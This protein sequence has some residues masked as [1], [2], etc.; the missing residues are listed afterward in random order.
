[1]YFN[2]VSN[3]R[4]LAHT[5]IRKYLKPWFVKSAQKLMRGLK[6]EDLIPS[7]KVGI[8]PQLVNVKTSSL[9]MDYIIEQTEDTLH[10]LNAISPAFTSSFAF[11]EWIVDQSGRV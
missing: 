3:F 5:E 9:E 2:N 11:S 8:R 7:S 4:L 1:M 10:V 6:S